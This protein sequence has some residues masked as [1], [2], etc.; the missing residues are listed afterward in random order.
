M[1]TITADLRSGYLVDISNGH[2][3]WRADEPVDLGGENTGPN[4]YEL[5]LGSLAACTCMTLSMYAKRKGIA[6]SSISAQ[7]TYDRVHADDCAFCD[8]DD[9]GFIDTVSS[10]IFVEGD[11]DEEQ[12]ERLVEVAVRCPV[13]KTLERGIRF[14]EDVFVG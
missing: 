7:Y 8:E 12:R 6:V 3:T 1:P 14:S 10:E 2:H 11:F 4:P 5:L 9:K 13:H